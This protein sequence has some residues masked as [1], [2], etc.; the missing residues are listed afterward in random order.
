MAVMGVKWD[1]KSPTGISTYK[2]FP[3]NPS[4][5]LKV[6]FYSTI[7]NKPLLLYET[8]NVESQ[9]I[10]LYACVSTDFVYL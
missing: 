1:K 10:H 6:S 8:T 3:K 5:S 2:Y 9:S 7:F 4:G